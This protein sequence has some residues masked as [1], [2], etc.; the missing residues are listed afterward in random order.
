MNRREK[1]WHKSEI[2]ADVA[3]SC[4]LFM[5]LSRVSLR[6]KRDVIPSSS[7][8]VQTCKSGQPTIFSFLLWCEN[9]G[10]A[11]VTIQSFLYSANM[12]IS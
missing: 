5:F 2:G 10:R 9:Y 12:N 8:C 7:L 1:K 6:R 3:S 4:Y 11:L